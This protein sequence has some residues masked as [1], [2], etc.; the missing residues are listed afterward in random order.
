MKYSCYGCVT[1]RL[2]PGT[3]IADLFENTQIMS[4]GMKP[5][6]WSR[7]TKETQVELG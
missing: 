4:S 5:A 2:I 6:K 1:Y 7:E 3:T